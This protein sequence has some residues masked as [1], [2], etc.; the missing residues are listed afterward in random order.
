MPL[1]VRLPDGTSLRFSRTF[2]VGRER[3]CEVELSDPQV[4]RRH[5]EVSET[6]GRWTIRDLQSSNGL[7][8]NGR[9]VESAAIATSE[10]RAPRILSLR[11]VVGKYSA[12][13]LDAHCLAFSQSPTRF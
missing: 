1:I 9:R 12:L 8:V 2:Y 3:G 7:F 5:A 10:I 13:L 11:M 4:S 6:A